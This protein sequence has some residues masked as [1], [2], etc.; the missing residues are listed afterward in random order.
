MRLWVAIRLEALPPWYAQVGE[1][2][3]LNNMLETFLTL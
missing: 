1:I 3:F 2:A